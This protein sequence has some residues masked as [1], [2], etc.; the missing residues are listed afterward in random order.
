[1]FSKRTEP[2]SIA[3]QLILFFTAAAAL[4]L[5]I[6]LGVFYAIVVRHAFAEDNAIF[7]DK[8]SALAADLRESSPAEFAED[9]APGAIPCRFRAGDGRS[10][11]GR[12]AAN[13]G[14]PGLLVLCVGE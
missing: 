6:G 1:M 2:R 5:A 3:S 7:A 11:C 12:D 8:I 9:H 10:Q 14:K 13:R 4:L